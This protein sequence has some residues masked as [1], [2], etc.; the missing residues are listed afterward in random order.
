MKTKIIYFFIGISFTVFVA[1]IFNYYF[2]T[3]EATTKEGYI[4]RYSTNEDTGASA[5]IMEADVVYFDTDGDGKEENII[6][7]SCYLCNAPPRELAIIDDGK[8]VFFYEGG[9]L[10]FIPVEP[11]SFVIEEANVPSDG[12]NIENTYEF[13]AEKMNYILSPKD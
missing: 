4:P 6:L 12:R 1:G 5:R 7:Y 9:Q 10:N 11:G 13:N 3:Q 2:P 8:M